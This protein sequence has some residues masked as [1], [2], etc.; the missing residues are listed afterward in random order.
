MKKF[1]FSVIILAL[2]VSTMISAFAFAE[3]NKVDSISSPTKKVKS[4]KEE[5]VKNN[6]QV[7]SLLKELSDL[8]AKEDEL[9]LKEDELEDSYESGKISYTSYVKQELELEKQDDLLDLR[10]HEIKSELKNLGYYVN[11]NYDDDKYDH[12]DDYDDDNCYDD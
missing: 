12:D 4:I 7:E 3:T 11:K 5:L 1:I 8:G 9:D 2:V 10:E 6:P